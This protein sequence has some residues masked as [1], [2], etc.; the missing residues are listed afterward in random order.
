MRRLA[1][2][3]AFSMLALF[4]LTLAAFAQDVDTPQEDVEE[5]RQEAQQEAAAEQQAGVPEPVEVEDQTV[6]TQGVDV[7]DQ[8]V[9]PQGGQPKQMPKAEMPKAEKA[10]AKAEKAKEMPKTGGVSV[11]SAL[12]PAAGLLLVGSGVMVL[13]ALR[14][15]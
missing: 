3:V 5:E 6:I 14:R 13:A 2:V 10:K 7:E 4:G 11:T 15:R 1:F 9:I 8:T 12:L